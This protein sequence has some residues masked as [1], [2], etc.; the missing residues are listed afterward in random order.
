MGTRGERG[1]K[2]DRSDRPRQVKRKGMIRFIYMEYIS[3][4]CKFKAFPRKNACLVKLILL[5]IVV[6]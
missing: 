6:Y 4:R 2:E 1:Q 5:I 3:L